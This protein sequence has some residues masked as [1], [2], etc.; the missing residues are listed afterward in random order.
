MSK[1]I[2]L[3]RVTPKSPEVVTSLSCTCHQAAG[4]AAFTTVESLAAGWPPE[5][6]TPVT[7]VTPGLTAVTVVL[8]G[9]VESVPGEIVAIVVS[10]TVKVTLSTDAVQLTVA[11]MVPVVPPITRLRLDGESEIVHVGLGVGV[12]T[13]TWHPGFAIHWEL[14]IQ[15]AGL[16][17]LVWRI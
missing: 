4:G 11:V 15:P 3:G 16:T 17:V 8:Y 9:E 10:P 13:P 1:S 14:L 6:T 2:P 12:G 7:V 5:D